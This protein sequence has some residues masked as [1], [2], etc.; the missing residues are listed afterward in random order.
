MAAIAADTV[1]T[2]PPDGHEPMLKFTIG[3]LRQVN[4]YSGQADYAG[5]AT[6]EN[7]GS[8]PIPFASFYLYLLD[9]NHK[10]IGEGY[11]EV[12]TLNA[13]QQAKVAVTAHAMGS[14]ASMELQPQHLPSD[15]PVKVKMS[16]VSAPAGA[17]IKLDSQ[18]AGV[19]P[20]T[21]AL[22]PGKHVL[23]FSKE[24][25]EPASTPLEVAAGALPGAVNVE[26]T[27][28]TLDTVVLR[29]ATVILGEVSSVS[30]AAV[31]VTVNGKP[32]KIERSQVAR[33]LFAERKVVKPAVAKTGSKTKTAAGKAVAPNS[34]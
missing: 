3:K 6:V 12:S 34:H 1:L 27:P 11:V 33:I 19:T 8:K 5:E 7:V 31:L 30:S 14:I 9:K 4:S 28:L 13:G 22:V 23:E 18:D 26:L 25:Y 29:D 17:S 16:L 15:E 2:W 10:R 24:G 20:T 21:L 32:R